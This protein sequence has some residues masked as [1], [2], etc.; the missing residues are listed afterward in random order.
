MKRRVSR[1]LAL[2]LI[3]TLMAGMAVPVS[4]A[5]A[6]SIRG[7]KVLWVGVGKCAV[8]LDNVPEGAKSFKITSSKPSVIK[9]GKDSS[10]AFGMWMKPLKTGKAKITITY[11]YAGKTRKIVDTYQAKKYP[12]PFASIT[13]DGN[14]TNLKK[15]KVM[16]EVNGYTKKSV[17]VNYKLNSGWKV[18]S[19]TGMKFGKT[20]KAFTW[21]KNQA[22]SFS[23]ASTLVFSILLVNKSNGDEFEYLV[24]VSR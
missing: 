3:L 11:M 9:V 20:D 7:T 18:K 5:G 10:D 2:V 14:K 24:M 15:N 19:L 17:K 23:S 22:V 8:L 13:V 1:I 6:P 4:A 12:N 16:T 21:K